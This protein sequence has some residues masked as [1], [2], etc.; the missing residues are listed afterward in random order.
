[1]G[2]SLEVF[3]TAVFHSIVFRLKMQKSTVFEKNDFECILIDLKCRWLQ[4]GPADM[5]KYQAHAFCLW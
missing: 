3:G 2:K 4:P 1:M 5:E